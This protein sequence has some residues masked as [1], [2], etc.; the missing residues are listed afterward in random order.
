MMN[1]ATPTSW[2]AHSTRIYR[3]LLM[4]YPAEYR[5]EYGALM[6]QVF[7]DVARDKYGSGGLTGIVLWWCSTLLDLTLTVIEQRK[8]RFGMSKS[9]FMQ[10]AGVFLIVGGVFCMGASYSQL[11]PGDHYSYYGLYQASLWLLAPAYMLFGF[12]WIALAMRYEP[13]HGT[14][15]KWLLIVSGVTGILMGAG[16][17]ASAFYSD[18]WN[19]W[20]A[21]TVIHVIALT[22]YGVLHV[23]KPALPAFRGLP[24]MIASGWLVMMTGIF[25]NLPQ[26][27]ENLLSFAITLGMGLGWLAI[28]MAVNR[29]RR[30]AVLAAA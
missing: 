1:R 29:Q 12:G 3:A 17:A 19:L 15:G 27:Y 6:V 13:G 9:T 11:Q 24:L 8:G 28:G 21:V 14:A 20:Y 25:E 23:F 18:W 5:R 4:L 10:L 22:L 26:N 16:L 7:R 30:A 2:I